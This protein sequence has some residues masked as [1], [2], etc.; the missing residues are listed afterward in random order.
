MLLIDPTAPEERRT[1]AISE[2]ES[3][4]DSGGE[5]V[6]QLRLGHPADGV[7]DRPPPGGRVPALPVQRRQRAAR[8][9]QPAPPDHRRG[10]A[11]PHHQGQAG[12]AHA[13]AAGPAAR[14]A[15]RTARRRTPRSPPARRRPPTRR[16]ASWTTPC[17]AAAPRRGAP[18]EAAPDAA[19]R[20][21]RVIPLRRRPRVTASPKTPHFSATS[22]APG[23]RARRTRMYSRSTVSAT[24]RRS[25]ASWQQ[26]T[27]TG[28]SSRGTSRA[29]PSSRHAERHGGLQPA[30]GRATPAARTSRPASG[31]TSP[32][33]STSPC[34][35]RR[36]RTAPSTSPRDARW[37]S[38][39]GSSGASGQDK[40]GK[41]RQSIDII[42]DSVQFLG[43][44]EGGENGGRFTPQSDVPADT[45]DFAQAPV[46]AGGSDDDIPF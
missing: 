23:A 8:A 9:P 1:A 16:A 39:G 30:D 36:A 3:M 25:P 21:G 10:A 44:R 4:I 35:A 5:L 45:A 31:S 2:A 20:R 32:T 42:A 27:S 18:A 41:K 43:S 11:L 28:W 26:R 12:P 13:A 22:W 38:T 37:R 29:T 46:A 34:G 24:S 7:R 14:A 40:D 33:T 6:G 19:A 17:A 15:A